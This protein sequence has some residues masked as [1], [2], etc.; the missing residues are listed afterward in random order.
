MCE[1]GDH[2]KLNP[3]PVMFR[4]TSVVVFL[5]LLL[6]GLL[7][8]D[9]ITP[10]VHIIMGIAVLAVAI[11]TMV[12]TIVSKQVFWQLR[13]L[14]IGLVALILVQAVLGFATLE[15]GSQIIAMVHFVAALG[16]YGMT[17]AGTFMASMLYARPLQTEPAVKEST[18]QSRV[19]ISYP[20]SLTV[21]A[22]VE[23]L[24]G[25]T[26]IFGGSILLV[27]SPSG[28]LLTFTSF[29]FPIGVG[30]AILGVASLAAKRQAWMLG[31][32]VAI[33]SIVDDVVA[34]GFVSL[35]F[36]GVIGTSVVL[37]M[38]LIAVYFL[39]RPDIRTYFRV[40]IS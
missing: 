33:I 35:P 10:L 25:V 22:L 9:F 38:A 7:T 29:H 12:L 8:F 16:I 26:F 19:Q 13:G 30:F 27:S 36:P 14:S 34:L 15:S 37:V 2:S 11:T 28:A 40:T 4:I 23:I 1:E 6:G 39:A 32:V 24:T 3:V 20:T 31:L 17:V 18:G 21:L 5:Q